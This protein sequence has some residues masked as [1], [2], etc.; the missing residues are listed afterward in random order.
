MNI[1]LS[2]NNLGLGGVTTYVA[3]LAEGLSKNHRVVIFDHYPYASDYN[4]IAFLPAQVKIESVLSH[5]LRDKLHWKIS[6]LLKKLGLADNY[7]DSTRK[8][9]FKRVLGIYDIHLI[10]SFDK[11][12]DKLVV[13]AVGNKVPLVLSLHGSYDISEFYTISKE[14]I[15]LFEP[16][17]RTARAIVYKTDNN[18][19]IL[20]EYE[21]L[22]NLRVI[23]K[24]YHGFSGLPPQHSPAS[25][26]KRLKI[27]KD[28]F[29]FGMIARGVPE[30]GWREAILAFLQVRN[31]TDKEIHF[32]AIGGGEYLD[33][34][35]VEFATGQNVHFTGVVYSGHRVNTD[36][37]SS[38]DWI[39]MLDVGVL[40]TY[41]P[42]ENYSFSVVEYM[43]C[44]KPTIA[45]NHGEIAVTLDA[46]GEKA[47]LLVSNVN[48]RPDI[49]GIKEA[50]KLYIYNKV[51]YD[52][53]KKLTT[54]AVK[55]FSSEKAIAEYEE[56]FNR[57]VDRNDQPM[58]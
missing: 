54:K 23:K 14:E 21:R 24:I 20:K 29:I 30:K 27:K 38:T 48:G 50:M 6:G 57:V 55:K 31:E 36:E 5:P 44:G 45:S 9:Y 43:F 28:A 1:L 40:P 56:V 19:R 39:N 10:T 34:L 2:V 41:T 16:V 11:Y 17:F 33:E 49:E 46:G 25:M 12:S 51:I 7:W 58:Q 4:S 37:P 47:G 22:D 3:H 8:R 42:T 13:D 52:R 35:K 53:H 15:K 26:R 32:V 18:I